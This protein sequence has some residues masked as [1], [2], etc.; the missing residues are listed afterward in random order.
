VERHPQR[1]FPLCRALSHQKTSDLRVGLVA[2]ES[3]AAIAVRVNAGVELVEDVALVRTGSVGS[4]AVAV[5]VDARV[6]SIGGA[7]AVGA[8]GSLMGESTL[9]AV[10]AGQTT[11]AVAVRV[12]T[13][14]S[15]IGDARAVRAMGSLM[16]TRGESTLV[17][18]GAGQTTAAVAV[19]VDARVSSIG[20]A[21]AVRAMGAFGAAVTSAMGVAAGGESTLGAGQ[22][23]AVGAMSTMCAGQTTAG[24][25]GDAS[26][27][28]TM[29]VVR[30][31]AKGAVMVRVDAR[32]GRVRKTRVVGAVGTLRDVG[33][34]L[35]VTSKSVAVVP[36][37]VD[38]G[39]DA[40]EN[41][42]IVR[43]GGVGVGR[44]VGSCL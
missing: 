41:V 19:R 32:V 26:H 43:A 44:H 23:T 2:T 40:V 17:A 38:A 1:R 13:R 27:T 33:A 12:D 37:R 25:A 18:V 35:G 34:C 30:A 29:G 5:R 4:R 20:D 36:V 24:G 3:L 10:G 8:M 11:A 15:S 22:T 9:V 42:V 7:R 39:V 6:S 14:V 21:R 16:G 28:S 31:G